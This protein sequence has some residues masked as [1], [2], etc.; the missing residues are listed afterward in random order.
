MLRATGYSL[1]HPAD[2]RGRDGRATF[3]VYML[4]AQLLLVVFAFAAIFAVPVLNLGYSGLAVSGV[5]ITIVGLL[6]MAGSVVRRLH[7]SGLSGWIAV[8]P[9]AIQLATIIPPLL[10]PPE[11]QADT[12]LIPEVP[13][14]QTLLEWLPYIIVMIIGVL[15]A[16]PGANRYGKE[17]R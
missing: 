11:L 5:S 7:D 3:W 8:I 16:T 9:A 4:A 17:A 15:P 13:L 12:S 2:F 10:S 1:R 14:Y 6:L